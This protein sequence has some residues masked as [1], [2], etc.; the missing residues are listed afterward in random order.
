MEVRCGAARMWRARD[1]GGEGVAGARGAGLTVLALLVLFT[2]SARAAAPTDLAIKATA[3]SFQVGVDGTYFITVTNAGGRN[4]DAPVRVTSTLPDGL[5]FVS[6]GGGG[7]ACTGIGRSVECSSAGVPARTTVALTLV[8]DACTNASSVLTALSVL[9]DGDVNSANDTTRR[10]TSVKPGPCSI[11]VATPTLPLT[12]TPTPL[13]AITPLFTSTPAPA[14]T[15]LQLVTTNAALFTIGTRPSYLHTLT[16]VGASATNVPMTLVNTLPIGINLVSAQGEG[17]TCGLSGRDVICT[18]PSALAVGAT[19]IVTLIVEVTADAYPTVTDVA[20][21]TYPADIDESDNTTRHPTTIRRTRSLRVRPQRR[22]PIRTV[23]PA[24]PTPTRTPTRT[25][26]P[27]GTP[28]AQRTTA[29]DLSLVNASK[30]VFK[31]G[32]GAFYVLKVTNVGPFSTNTPIVLTDTLPDSLRLVGASGGGWACATAGQTLTCTYPDPLAPGALA[33]LI[34]NVNV[35][36]AAFP[37]VVNV[38][39]VI[40]VS[41]TNTRNNTARRPTTVHR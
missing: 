19:S 13:V 20:T 25:P 17:W 33:M 11:R 7:F 23:A 9:Y 16:N 21:L 34:V 10:V 37:S 22:A 32:S 5:T 31:A 3:T 39:T 40:Y 29:T 35:S 2:G 36:A 1:V 26:T 15:D 38:A 6:G 30:G 12:P 18:H 28:A 8:V 41:D 4:T 14:A 24:A 27:T